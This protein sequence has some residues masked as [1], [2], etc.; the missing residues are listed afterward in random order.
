MSKE[1]SA[2]NNI[3]PIVVAFIGL[4]GGLGGVYVG[5]SLSTDAS[6]EAVQYSYKNELLQQ[7]IKLINRA[8]LIYGKSPGVKDVWSSYLKAIEDKL[9]PS[10][11]LSKA[12]AEYNAEFNAVI[13]LSSLYFGPKTHDALEKMGQIDSPWWEKD[14][15]LVKNYMAAMVSELKYSIQ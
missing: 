6:Q 13:N 10:I 4:F 12:L 15:D 2:S 3:V 1:N 5:S 8:A 14:D 9:E 7:R 11:E